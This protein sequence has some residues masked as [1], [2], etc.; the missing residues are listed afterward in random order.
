MSCGLAP[1]ELHALHSFQLFRPSVHTYVR[2]SSNVRNFDSFVLLTCLPQRV[3]ALHDFVVAERMVD[4]SHM[5][6][7]ELYINNM[8]RIENAREDTRI[9][10][11]VGVTG[12]GMYLIH[13]RW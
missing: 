7:F 1:D 4:A 5:S 8:M 2:A 3:S 13:V 9:L 6:T 12:G 11:D 10:G